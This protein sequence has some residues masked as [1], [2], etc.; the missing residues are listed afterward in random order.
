MASAG[1]GVW[2]ITEKGLQRLKAA[3]QESSAKAIP[4]YHSTELSHS[5][6]AAVQESSANAAP[7]Y[8]S[9][10]ISQN[11]QFVNLEELVDAYLDA[12]EQKVIQKLGDLE[13]SEFEQFAGALISSYGFTNVVVTKK[14]RD[15]G[16]DGHGELKVGLAVLKAAF[17]CKKWTGPVGSPDIDSFRGAIQGKFEHGY[18]FTTSSFSPDAQKKS[19]QSGAAPI[20]LFDGHAIVKLMLEKGLGVRRK[21]IE[22]YEDQIETL[23]ESSK[24]P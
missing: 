1:H 9:I 10:G 19:F 18:F 21:P 2:A 23:F 14:S 15:G 5:S 4:G 17:Q 6:Q 8:P 12:F 20:T 7:D 3:T 22:V 13:A 16:I 24:T 11:S